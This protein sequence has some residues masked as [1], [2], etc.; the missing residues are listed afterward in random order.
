MREPHIIAGEIGGESAAQIRITAQDMI[1]ERNSDA[2]AK[3]G[4]APAQGDPISQRGDRGGGLS[5]PPR[6]GSGGTTITQSTTA[7]FLSNFLRR[8]AVLI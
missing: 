6:S 3:N 4:F 8:I 7:S 5:L 1:R 2:D